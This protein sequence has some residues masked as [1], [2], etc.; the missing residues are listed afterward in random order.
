M[1]AQVHIRPLRL[2]VRLPLWRAVMTRKRLLQPALVPKCPVCGTDGPVGAL[3]PS[4]LHAG[5]A[6]SEVLV[7]PF[8]SSQVILR[9]AVRGSLFEEGRDVV[10][11]RECLLVVVI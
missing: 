5:D 11:R 10:A 6:L 1:V 3:D 9:C 8:D 2:C 4:L 7:G